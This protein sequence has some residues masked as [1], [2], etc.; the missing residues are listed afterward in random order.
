MAQRKKT[1][2]ELTM[3]NLEAKSKL[4][5]VEFAILLVGVQM[6]VFAL[7][8]AAALET[9]RGQAWL[10]VIIAGGVYYLAAWMMIRLGQRYPQKTIVEYMPEIWGKYLGGT[11]VW[12][13][14]VAVTLQLSASLQA[15]SREV[16]FF[17]FDRTPY[18]IIIITFVVAAAYC[19]VQDLGTIIRVTQ[20]VFCIG[21]FL[22][23]ALL[24][25]SLS[26]FQITNVLP[27]WQGNWS[28]LA[29][30]VYD[31]WMLFAGYSIIFI[32]MPQVSEQKRLGRTVGLT[33]G[34][35]TVLFTFIILT[36]IGSQGI[37][38]ALK[39]P[40]PLV[41]VIRAV[42]IPGTFLERLDTYLIVIKVIILY[43]SVYTYLYVLAETLRRLY[44]Y[45]DRRP[46]VLLLLPV[47]FF[48]SDA[49]HT[50]WLFALAIQIANAMGLI[51]S[52][53]LI[54]LTL[55]LARRKKCANKQAL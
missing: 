16:T 33:F 15:F 30:G 22:S 14:I 50:A 35:C 9:A 27:L 1:G 38:S 26:T 44:D 51:E 8:F 2:V 52:F 53:A 39:S 41:T 31:D 24:L 54:P 20:I 46:F 55:F 10:S 23:I 25:L 12:W 29:G 43:I 34:Y 40:F 3:P 21:S 13:F 48:I 6:N 36:I 19:A 32:L 5:A 49:L 42:E 28:Q 7:S 45:R 11:M 37:N 18:E 17:L 47:I 4:T